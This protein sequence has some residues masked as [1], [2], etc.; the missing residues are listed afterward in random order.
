[1]I[2]STEHHDLFE[3][4]IAADKAEGIALKALTEYMNTQGADK[5]LVDQLMNNWMKANEYKTNLAGELNKV[6]IG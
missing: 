5:T 4:F 1:M 3:R 6:R 2:V